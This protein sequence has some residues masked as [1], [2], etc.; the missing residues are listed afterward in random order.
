[1][2][3]PPPLPSPLALGA[4]ALVALLSLSPQTARAQSLQEATGLSYGVATLELGTLLLLGGLAIGDAAGG[5]HTRNPFD[6]ELLFGL[7]A[8]AMVLG[9]VASIGIAQ[10]E[11][12]PVLPAQ[13]FHQGFAGASLLGALGYST[14]RLSGDDEG[15]TLG[16]SIGGA[17]LGAAGAVSYAAVRGE[18]IVAEERDPLPAWNWAFGPTVAG[19]FFGGLA[20]FVADRAGGVDPGVIGLLVGSLAGLLF[21]G[22]AV[23]A[24]ETSGIAEPPP[25]APGVAMPMDP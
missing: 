2:M 23:L 5:P 9:S 18:R 4:V 3:S 19:L 6:E 12:A 15:L 14:G 11:A 8:A 16:L 24:V 20:A 10:S 25:I 1:M 21:Y 13:L 17:I 22:L 7:S